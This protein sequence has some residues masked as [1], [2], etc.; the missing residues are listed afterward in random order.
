MSIEAMSGCWGEDFPCEAENIASSTV[1]LIALAIADTV[2]DLGGNEFYGSKERL[3]AKCGVHRDTVR[4]VVQHLTDA[5]VVEI[6]RTRSG[7]TTVYRWSWKPRGISA[8]SDGNLADSPRGTSRTDP[9]PPRGTSRA[10]TKRTQGEPKPVVTQQADEL[11]LDDAKP[12]TPAQEAQ[13][14]LGD[15]WQFVEARSGRKPIGVTA[16]AFKK[17][18]TPFLEAGVSPERVAAAVTEMY[19]DGSTLTR[20]G[21]ERQL[22]GRVR[23][24]RKSTMDKLRE[25]EFDETGALLV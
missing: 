12:R 11:N 6:L 24:G 4:L 7:A 15:Y 19:A 17:L 13:R 16:I 25:A 18:V 20:Q 10:N 22:D 8:G 5:G 2:N 1:R 14:L 23:N 21:I 9:R 3:A